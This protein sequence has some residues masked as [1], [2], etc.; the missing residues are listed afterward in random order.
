MEV[1]KERYCYDEDEKMKRINFEMKI[2]GRKRSKEVE[3]SECINRMIKYE[4]VEWLL[5]WELEMIKFV[6]L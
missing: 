3:K 1:K 5:I 2:K 4:L 6:N